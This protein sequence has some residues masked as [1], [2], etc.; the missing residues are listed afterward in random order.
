MLYTEH[1][2]RTF[3]SLDVLKDVTFNV[4]DGERAGLVGPNG[5]GK[6]TILRLIAGEDAAGRGRLRPSRRI[7]GLS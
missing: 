1:V 4:S 5:A 3:G 2:A 6:S 7:A